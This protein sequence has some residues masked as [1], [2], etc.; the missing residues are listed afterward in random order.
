MK[1]LTLVLCSLALASTALAHKDHCEDPPKADAKHD[2][3][4]AA[5][6]DKLKGMLGTWKCDGK[7]ADQGKPTQHA[8]KGSMKMTSELGGHWILVDYAEEKTKENP[9]P[10]AFK[11]FI[12]WDK[13]AGKYQRMFVDNMGGSAKMVAAPAAADGTMEWTGDVMMGGRSVPMKDVVTMKSAKE[14]LIE[15]SMQGPDGAWMPVAS[16]TCKK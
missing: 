10:F 9:M 16:L 4:P 11:E 7:S 6:M 5:E 15:V 1:T 3:K 14:T 8:I 2:R 13:A 12:G